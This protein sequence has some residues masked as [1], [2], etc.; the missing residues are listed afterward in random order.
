MERRATTPPFLLD[1][2]D[3]TQSLGRVPPRRAPESPDT[4]AEQCAPSPVLQG[5]ISLRDV[6]HHYTTFISTFCKSVNI[7][8]F[9]TFRGT[10]P[11][12]HLGVL[13]LNGVKG[14][15]K[16]MFKPVKKKE[17]VAVIARQ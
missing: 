11:P 3:E 1:P 9:L 14:R 4:K 15:P 8:S 5:A 12:R 10:F 7:P 2:S 13:R 16:L 6:A 17:K